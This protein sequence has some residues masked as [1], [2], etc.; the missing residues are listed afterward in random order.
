MKGGGGKS[1]LEGSLL[2]TE[3]VQGALDELDDRWN[4]IKV[5]LRNSPVLHTPLDKTF[6]ALLFF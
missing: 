3:P 6:P 1:E 5:A 2:S 4:Q